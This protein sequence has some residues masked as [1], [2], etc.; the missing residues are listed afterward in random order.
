MQR[1]APYPLGYKLAKR[2]WYN[3]LTYKVETDPDEFRQRQYIICDFVELNLVPF[4]KKNG[5]VLACEPRRLAE[6]ISRVLYF[7]R[8][9]HNPLNTEYLPE[10]YDHYYWAL[11]DD[12]WSGFWYN[13]R[14]WQDL[15]DEHR[16]LHEDIRFCVWTMLDLDYSKQTRVVNEVLG[17]IDDDDTSSRGSEKDRNTKDPYLRDLERGYYN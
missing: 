12:K 14:W 5:Y 17:I 2:Q 15:G 4:I 1:Y 6:C 3:W 13:W 16:N 7:G 11:N 8:I 9:R 10:D